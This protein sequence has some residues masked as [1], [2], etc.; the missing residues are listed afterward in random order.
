MGLLRIITRIKR[1]LLGYL[2]FWILCIYSGLFPL[3]AMG[4]FSVIEKNS[5]DLFIKNSHVILQTFVE[6]L[7]GTE[8]R[9][10][11]SR[12]LDM[13]DNAVFVG[14]LSYADMIVD[15]R[16]IT[17]NLIDQERTKN[18]REDRG[19]GEGGDQIYFVSSLLYSENSS[20]AIIMRFGFDENPVEESIRNAYLRASFFFVAYMVSTVL[21]LVVAARKVTLP[22]S[23]LRVN[24][25]FIASGQMGKRIDIESSFDEVRDLANDM[26]KMR[27]EIV[28]KS[29]ILEKSS[30]RDFL[31]QLPNR[32]VFSQR[33]QESICFAKDNNTSFALLI[34]DLDRF[35]E[36]NDGL[37]HQT[38][39]LLLQRLSLSMLG[40]IEI[41]DFVG[42]LSGDEFAI[43]LNKADSKKVESVCVRLQ[44]LIREPYKVNDRTVTVGA[45]FG[46]AFYPRHGSNEKDLMRHADIAMYHAKK[47]GLSFSVFVE[48]QDEDIL[49]QMQLRSDFQCALP[50]KEL[51]VY[52]QPKV[53]LVD[54]KISGFEA[55]VRWQHPTEGLI[56]PDDFLLLAEQSGLI[57]DLTFYVLRQATADTARWRG[58]G[59]DVNIAVNIA[60][61]N[62]TR[63]AF[64]QQVLDLIGETGLSAK[65]IELELTENDIL[66]EPV[67]AIRILET[68]H[69]KEIKIVVDDY[70]TGYSS[71]TYLKKLPISILK[72]D[73]S[74]VMEMQQDD[75]NSE[76]I[77]ASILMAHNIGLLVVAEGVESEDAMRFL[78]SC[79]CD[80]GQGYYFSKPVPG[81]AI[82]GLLESFGV[83]MQP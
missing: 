76:I 8:L 39:D 45:S 80:W 12:L 62:L 53:R 70:G 79:G 66:D 17:S 46:V 59:Y 73:K 67:Q 42:R 23:K 50:N 60:P 7:D 20:S 13:L 10:A 26:E 56:Q 35:K 38:G 71:L 55:L 33:L 2:L 81:S 24:S 65:H 34:M 28:K 43:I 6:L 78:K 69:K 27:S 48:H 54:Q 30:N 44:G 9:G 11:E 15:G 18:F 31:T 63:D 25:Q 5:Q 49:R 68:L 52:Y 72:I 32:L 4:I 74:F 19:F 61:K 37:G 83:R 75:D 82:L 16:V 29:R 14:D 3:V 22:I 1:S 40:A 58:L 36:I 57:N 41:A 51:Q 64:S 77:K 21:V 47:R